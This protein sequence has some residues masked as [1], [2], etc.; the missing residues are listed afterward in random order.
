M[1]QSL[2]P[3]GRSCVC[4]E[5]FRVLFNG[6]YCI[7]DCDRL[8]DLVEVITWGGRPWKVFRIDPKDI[9][10]DYRVFWWF[11][12]DG[13]KKPKHASYDC[14]SSRGPGV[15]WSGPYGKIVIEESPE[16]D[17]AEYHF[18]RLVKA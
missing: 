1:N 16:P 15:S 6:L 4:G 17:L 13:P 2:D 11:V 3:L 8:T 9:R 12:T 18:V 7:K 5:T 14:G 10:D